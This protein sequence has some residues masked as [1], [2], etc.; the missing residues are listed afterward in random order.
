MREFIFGYG[1]LINDESRRR[2]AGESEGIAAT[3]VLRDSEYERAWCFHAASG[4]T[5]LG[6]RTAKRTSAARSASQGVNGVLF[7]V[8]GG[9]AVMSEFDLREEGYR[10]VA[11]R[12]EQLE[13]QRHCG[14]D[15]TQ[16]DAVQAALGEAEVRLWAYVVLNN[17][18]EHGTC[19]HTL[20]ACL[21][22]LL[23]CGSVE[24]LNLA[25]PESLSAVHTC[26]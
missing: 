11:L 6:M 20:L 14:C 16:S 7:E 9:D 26:V 4:F 25:R 17:T 1:S 21:R 19:T 13:V 22:G 3:V 23:P 24:P 18:E 8:R 2:T 15:S 5:A 12:P 10:R